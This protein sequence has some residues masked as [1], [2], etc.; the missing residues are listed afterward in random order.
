MGEPGIGKTRLAEELSLAAYTRDWAVAWSR[1]YE[2]EGTIPYRP[3][4]E[5]L[6]TLL[7]GTSA[8]ELVNGTSLMKQGAL[9]MASEM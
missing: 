5:F 2:Q 6:R 8:R 7:Q 4:T 9:I 3:W 1:S